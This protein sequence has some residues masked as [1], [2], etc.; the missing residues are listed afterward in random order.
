MR[1]LNN[2]LLVYTDTIIVYVFFLDSAY[3][4]I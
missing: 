3:I 4:L 2:T 1:V